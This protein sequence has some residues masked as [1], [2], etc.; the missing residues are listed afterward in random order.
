MAL[1]GKYW[2]IF[3]DNGLAT[4]N[5]TKLT[6]TIGDQ[7]V[8]GY[9]EEICSISFTADNM[10]P[11]K[12]VDGN[13]ALL[14]QTNRDAVIT[15]SLLQTSE[16]NKWL[17]NMQA[18]MLDGTKPI[19]LPQVTFSDYNLG[20][21]WM[22]TSAYIQKH[23]DLTYGATAG[24]TQWSLYCIQCRPKQNIKLDD[25]AI[26]NEEI[27]FRKVGEAVK[28]LGKTIKAVFD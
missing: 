22:S 15:F 8:S 5:P 9:A 19:Q 18:D 23:P 25:S 27:L 13:T 11:V 12:G 16:T 3:K 7:L 20:V 21:A 26:S 28:S 6:L 14:R 1:G 4:Y 10:T 24:V 17:L 2:S